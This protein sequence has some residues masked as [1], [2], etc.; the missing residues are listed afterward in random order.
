M[1]AWI[2]NHWW[3][4]WGLGG[5]GVLIVYRL[6]NTP[7][8]E[9]VTGEHRSVIT[10]LFDPGGSQEKLMPQRLVL[11]AVGL[12]LVL[13]AMGILKLLERSAG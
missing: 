6:R 5:A 12:L 4:F 10:R 13:A 9:P 1:A 8:D 2:A 3:M 11:M 7:A